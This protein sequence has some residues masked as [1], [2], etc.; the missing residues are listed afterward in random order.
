MSPILP[1]MPRLALSSVARSRF[2][3][4]AGAL[5]GAA[6]ISGVFLGPGPAAM[7]V[8][9]A[10]LVLLA[11]W[12]I[13]DALVVLAALGPLGG[14]LAGLTGSAA[15]WS[16][17]LAFALVAGA[18]L[19]CAAKPRASKD[20]T[21]TGA[22]AAWIALALASAAAECWFRASLDVSSGSTFRNLLKWLL[23]QYP[24]VRPLP[25]G[26]V[27]AAMMT[28]AS[29]AVFAVAASACREESSLSARIT[30]ALVLAGAALGSLAVYRVVEVSLRHPPFLESLLAFAQSLRTSPVVSDVNAV[31]ALFLL[32]LPAAVG[33]V[34]GR[35]ARWVGVASL[36]W[37]LAGLWL[38]GSR[39][40]IA[41]LPIAFTVQAWPWLKHRAP[42]G[43]K[44]V[45]GLA[46]LAAAGA[47]ALLFLSKNVAHG[48]PSGA[49]AIRED[50]VTT[51][52]S[53]AYYHPLFGV[54]IGNYSTRSIEFM[55]PRLA[56]K[57]IKRDAHNQFLQVLGEMGLTG[58]V[59]FSALL[60]IGL[61]PGLR[62]LAR[63]RASPGLGGLVAGSMAFLT[64]S[65]GMHPLLIAE[66]NL[67]FF[68]LL[69]AA[70]AEGVSASEDSVKSSRWPWMGLVAG[71]AIFACAAVP[72][73]GSSF[74]REANLEGVSYGL[75]NWQDADGRRWRTS[76]LPAV[77]FVPA[78]ETRITLPLR[79]RTGRGTV[80]PEIQIRI[81]GRLI[82][83]IRVPKGAWTESNL[84]MPP[85]SGVSG[86]FRKLDLR[87]ADA[88]PERT[89]VDVGIVPLPRRPLKRGLTGGSPAPFPTRRRSR[90]TTAPARHQ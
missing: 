81:D 64:V 32:L 51:S 18:G 26:F 50:M 77:M 8:G 13:G 73:R 68:L 56:S 70:R 3:G 22:A 19:R 24:E 28:A 44:I 88:P 72:W 62:A 36:P 14:A 25:Y 53:M 71:V 23:V 48:S 75:S 21:A 7:K 46:V 30:R 79:V 47:A 69:G 2:L 86:S 65:L 63:G 45:A 84:D 58:L 66:V 16:T 35:S 82:G 10:A 17:P 38:A 87:W 90:R 5:L 85:P 12:R 41:L 40:A 89:A 15:S 33:I 55:P 52:L 59:V 74:A 34:A 4:L 27:F 54:G 20:P 83:T 43:R 49:V 42:S 11:V 76:R 29:A 67:A 39:T 61:A 78:S 6:G 31:S 1:R 9:V 60:A 80:I 57:N 37:L